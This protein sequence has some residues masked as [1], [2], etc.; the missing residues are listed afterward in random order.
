MFN[1]FLIYGQAGVFFILRCEKFQY[2]NIQMGKI[3]DIQR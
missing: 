1:A 2:S 3:F